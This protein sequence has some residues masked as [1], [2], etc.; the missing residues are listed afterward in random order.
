MKVHQHILFQARLPVVDAYTVVMPVQT[1]DEG[2]YRWL[3]EMTK[4][5]RCL[6]RLMAH[7]KCL[8][9]D[10]SKCI[11]HNLSFHGLYRINDYCDGARRELL[12]GL[13]CVD[14]DGG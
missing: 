2:L 10:Q 5:G 11:D 6:P 9:V 14:I 13:L 4:I 12:E 3:I 1:V 8:G 7:H